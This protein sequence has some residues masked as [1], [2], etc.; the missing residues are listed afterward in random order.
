MDL[1]VEGH[2]AAKQCYWFGTKK[3]NKLKEQY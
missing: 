3:K 2:F 1:E